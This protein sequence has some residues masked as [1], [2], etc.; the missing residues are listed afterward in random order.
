MR[1]TGPA[2]PPSVEHFPARWIDVSADADAAHSTVR[3]AMERHHYKP[4]GVMADGVARYRFLSPGV[5]FLSSA[6]GFGVILR[7]MGRPTGWAELVAWTE[8][9]PRGL[10]ITVSLT[11]GVFHG[12]EVRT[13]ITELIETFRR[14]GLLLD[15]SERFS[16]RDLPVG[17]PGRQR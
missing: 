12:K 3:A 16:S 6:L 9:A 10:R 13:M 8:P 2:D 5:D 14:D 15:V 17:S 11:E 4:Y 7:M 1:S